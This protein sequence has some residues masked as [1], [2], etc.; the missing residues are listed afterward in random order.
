MADVTVPQFSEVLKVPVDRLLQ[1]L[2]QAGIRVDSAEDMISEDAKHELLTHL[3]RSHGHGDVQADAAP[4]K[5]TL[6]RKSQSELKLAS[7]QGRARTVNVEVRSKRTYIKR[8]VLEDQARHQ[9]EEIDKQ[10]ETEEQAKAAL[11]RAE[12]ERLEKE[13]LDRERLEEE[14]RRRTDEEVRKRT[15]EE[16]ARRVA[17]QLARDQAE[18][19]RKAAAV[20]KPGKAARVVVDDKAAR[21]GRQELHIVGDV[22]SRHKKKKSR[23][24]RRRSVGG[25][26][27]TKHGFEMPTERVVRE[28]AIGEAMTVGELAQKMAVKATEVIKVMMNMGVMATINQMIEQDTAVLVVEEM[29]HTAVLRKENII[30]DDLQ[31][32]TDASLEVLPRPPVGT[33]MGHVD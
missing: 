31:G 28:V 26:S 18:R 1:Q 30:E 12:H 6:R 15:A 20:A 14:S 19:E 17:E 25:E 4:R 32:E 33:V 2:D 29:G 16:E 8:E 22:S 21:Y 13:R 23:D 9:Q 27:D 10:R 3:R 11:E 5:I 24:G 7:P